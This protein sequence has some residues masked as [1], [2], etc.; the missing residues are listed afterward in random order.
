MSHF[1]GQREFFPGIGSIP[2]EGRDS[3]NPLSFKFYDP[4]KRVMG[5][6]MKEHLRFAVCYWHSFCGTGSDPFGPGTR[7]FPWD[8]AST[9]IDKAK[10]KLDAAF[11]FVTKLGAEFYCFHDRDI[12]PAGATVAESEKNLQTLVSLAKERQA[13]TGVKLLWGT[14]NLFSD[15]RYMN[16]AATNPDFRVLTHAAAQVKAAIDATVQLGGAGYVFWGG[17]EGY[18]S[19]LNTDM[20]RELENLGRFLSMARDYGRAN[21]FR[22]TFYIEPKP[23]EPSKH[24][25]DFDASTVIGF[26]KAHGL[27]KDFKLNVEANH[28]TLAGHAFSH[29]LQV[30]ADAGLLGSIDANRGDPQN[31]WDTDQFPTDLY[32]ATEAMMIVLS[33]G[34]FTTGGL[35][36]DAKVRRNSTDLEDLFLAHIGGMDTFARGLEVASR[37]LESSLLKD[38]KQKRYASFTEG[39]GQKFSDGKLSLADLAKL[40]EKNEKLP[41][42]SGKQELLENIINQ[43]I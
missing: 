16:G 28:A 5:K 13:A 27:D 24:Q 25:Y 32:Q 4:N 37:L 18:T 20:K 40:A 9:P 15:P 17:R 41:L 21:G 34:G 11:E 35:N 3:K 42:I 7:Y 33:A 6:T 38:I 12:A 8:E 31:G 22:G 14:A 26:L 23:M 1:V 10:L 19:L 39:D 30:A 29:E 2:Y 36:F 43:Y